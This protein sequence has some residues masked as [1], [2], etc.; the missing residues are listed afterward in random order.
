VYGPN[1]LNLVL[2]NLGHYVGCYAIAGAILGA[3][4]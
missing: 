1:T 4:K 3:W 2:I